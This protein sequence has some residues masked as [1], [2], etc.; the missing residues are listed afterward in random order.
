MSNKL[1]RIAV[2]GFKSIKNIDVEIMDLN[3]LIGPNGAGKSNF[4]GV[5]KFLREII[6]KRLQLYTGVNGGANKIL[7]YGSKV[8]PELKVI[9]DY[10]PDNYEF[11][12]LPTV[13]D[14]FIFEKET[15]LFDMGPSQSPNLYTRYDNTG[16]RESRLSDTIYKDSLAVPS[17]IQSSLLDYRIYHFHDT[18]IDAVVKKYNDI[19]DTIYL[20][21][22]A[23]NLAAFLS[24]MKMTSEPHYQRIV[25]IIRLIVPYFKDFVFRPNPFNVSTIRLEWQDCNSDMTFNANDLSDGSLRFICLATL[26]LQPNI[27]GLILLD[28]PELGL[29]PSAINLLGSLIRKASIRSQLIISTQSVSLVNE[30]KPENILVVENAGGSSSFKRLSADSYISWLENYTLGEIWEQNIF[31]GKP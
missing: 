23:S 31:G 4:I 2:S 16:E 8:S 29:H 18:S 13:D 11:T 25:E 24:Y 19:T 17:I 3:V 15:L 6:E 12:L 10:K 20:K 21:E 22:N 27:P 26:L 7:H 5:F 1:N 14:T 30:F 28:E 9:L